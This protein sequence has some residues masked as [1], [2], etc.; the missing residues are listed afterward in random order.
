MFGYDPEE[1]HP[2]PEYLAK[3][4]NLHVTKKMFLHLDVRI[5]NNEHITDDE[6]MGKSKQDDDSGR[7]PDDWVAPHRGKGTVETDVVGGVDKDVNDDVGDKEEVKGVD[8]VNIK[9]VAATQ[10]ANYAEK[11][12]N[13]RESEESLYTVDFELDSLDKRF[14]D[15]SF[16]RESETE[17]TT[18]EISTADASKHR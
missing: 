16:S 5:L 9:D 7:S 3:L 14:G 17:S 2:R 13:N 4:R 15:Y 11:S 18:T 12:T 6:K 10:N 1:E 8:I